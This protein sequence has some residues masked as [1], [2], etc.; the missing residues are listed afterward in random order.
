MKILSFDIGIKNLAFC[1]ANYDIITKKLIIEEWDIINLLEDEFNKQ[2]ICQHINKNKPYNNCKKIAK[3][4]SKNK[5]FSFCKTHMSK[6]NIP[7]LSILPID[8]NNLYICDDIECSKKSKYYVNNKKLCPKH[9]NII[10]DCHN[11]NY[12][13][14]KIKNISANDYPIDKI[15]DYMIHILDNKY[16]HFLNSD[17]V[18]LELQLMKSPRIKTLSNYLY[19]YYRMNGIHYKKNNSNINDVR[20]I[21]ASSKLLFNKNNTKDDIDSYNNRK[22]TGID[23]VNEYLTINQLIDNKIWFNKQKK[24]D[25][26]ADALLQILIYIQ[27]NF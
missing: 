22:K 12:I 24:Q 14:K 13:F 21:M 15:T 26:L 11:Q 20:Y 9:K 2:L 4:N 6:F 23:N 8:N 27:R 17:I 3:F 10:L 19:M 7:E 25:D 16:L 5:K 18:L 1:L